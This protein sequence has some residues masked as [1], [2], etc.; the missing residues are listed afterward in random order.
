MI[1]K[2]ILIKCDVELPEKPTIYDYNKAFL[3]KDF[4]SK[5][6]YNQPRK[7]LAKK[8][9]ET[10]EIRNAFFHHRVKEIDTVLLK[11]TWKEL[12]AILNEVYKK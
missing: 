10:N 3:N 5:L 2:A 8:L 1:L 9:G 11:D 12:K 6:P 7:Q 4:F